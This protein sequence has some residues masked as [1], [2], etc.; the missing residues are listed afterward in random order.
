MLIKRDFLLQFLSSRHCQVYMRR[1]WRILSDLGGGVFSAL[2]VERG[3]DKGV[4]RYVLTAGPLAVIPSVTRSRLFFFIF[5]SYF[6]SFAF[7]VWDCLRK[8][9]WKFVRTRQTA[10]IFCCWW[11]PV[12]FTKLKENNVVANLSQTQQCILFIFILKKSFGHF[13]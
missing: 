2:T 7:S 10:V 8:I 3:W 5:T 11:H 12:V 1:T 9:K 13:L 6:F 4:R